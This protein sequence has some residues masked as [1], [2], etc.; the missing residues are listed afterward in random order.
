MRKKTTAVNGSYKYT[1]DKLTLKPYTE[2][3]MEIL[4][5][6]RIKFGNTTE[7][8]F[9]NDFKVTNDTAYFNEFAG[10]GKGSFGIKTDTKVEY[11]PENI[12]QLKADFKARYDYI[13]S[14]TTS[15]IAKSHIFE[16]ESN[17]SYD[18]DLTNGFKLTPAMRMTYLGNFSNIDQKNGIIQSVGSVNSNGLVL[19]PSTTLTYKYNNLTT[20]LKI[21]APFSFTSQKV[22]LKNTIMRRQQDVKNHNP[23][24]FQDVSL[25]ATLSIKYS[26]K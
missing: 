12:K 15:K 16:I 14:K 2:L 18:F 5:P 19:D 24:A 3:E 13:N 10:S 7:Y 4:T 6:T 1:Q 25:G 17:T 23:F 20:S 21:E 22:D 8:K 9:N 11:T 26:W